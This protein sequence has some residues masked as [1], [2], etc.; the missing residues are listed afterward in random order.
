MIKSRV[1]PIIKKKKKKKKKKKNCSIGTCF[2]CKMS[3]SRLDLYDLSSKPAGFQ[4]I[5]RVALWKCRWFL[6]RLTIFVTAP[7]I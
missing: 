1:I 6:G 2:S 4:L 7:E 5:R 3:P